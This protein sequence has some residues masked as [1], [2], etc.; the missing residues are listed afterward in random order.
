MRNILSIAALFAA[1]L[2]MSL[3][4]NTDKAE[5]RVTCSHSACSAAGRAAVAPAVRGPKAPTTN[6][7]A[8]IRAVTYGPTEIVWVEG[9]EQN[10]VNGRVIASQRRA[11]GYTRTFELNGG[12]VV[13]ESCIS[14]SKLANVS[15]VTI[16]NGAKVGE[17]Y[18]WSLARH[19][20]RALANGG[21]ASSYVP[22][23]KSRDIMSLSS[24][25]VDASYQRH[26][27]R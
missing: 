5:A 2:G 16:C 14:R 3:F 6:P 26:Y 21:H 11:S 19:E 12:W 24:T 25:V 10:Y 7:M 20:V 27:G 9:N 8:C 1:F 18:H 23:L 15:D 4:G 13:V 17:G 22:L